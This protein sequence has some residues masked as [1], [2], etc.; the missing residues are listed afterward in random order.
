MTVLPEKAALGRL[1]YAMSADTLLAMALADMTPRPFALIA[2][3]RR[4]F[5]WELDEWEPGEIAF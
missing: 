4:E 3:L 5:G 2:F 1:S